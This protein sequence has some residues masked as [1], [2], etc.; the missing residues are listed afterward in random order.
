MFLWI[1][2]GNFKVIDINSN[3]K[4]NQKM[5][6]SYQNIWNTDLEMMIENMNFVGISKAPF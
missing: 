3:D 1:G 4:S 5:G 2:T 6:T